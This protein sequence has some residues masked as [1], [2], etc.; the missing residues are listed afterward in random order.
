MVNVAL[1]LKLP[2]SR[3]RE[4]FKRDEREKAPTVLLKQQNKE[5]RPA[6]RRLT[7]RANCASETA[8][9]R[10]ETVAPSNN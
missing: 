7:D 8:Q 2:R 6:R 5:E 9:Q 3:E 4:D 1:S 10:E